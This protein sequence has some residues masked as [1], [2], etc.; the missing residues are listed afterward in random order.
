MYKRKSRPKGKSDG[1]LCDEVS[2]FSRLV[3][4]LHVCNWR[5]SRV[6]FANYTRC[7]F[8]T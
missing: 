4:E 6:K 3:G 7:V 5:T 8:R 1:L 2:N